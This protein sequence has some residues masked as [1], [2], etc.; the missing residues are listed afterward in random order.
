MKEL[1][2]RGGS[3]SWQGFRGFTLPLMGRT[4]V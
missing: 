1:G 2:Q 4:V 3:W